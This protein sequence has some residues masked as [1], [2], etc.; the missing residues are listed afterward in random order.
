[1]TINL[2]GAM[3]TARDRAWVPDRM[4]ADLL[5]PLDITHYAMNLMPDGQGYL[6][7]GLYLRTRD[8]AKLAQLFLDRGIWRGKRIV[9]A[10]WTEQATARH[11]SLSAPDDYGFGWWRKTLVVEGT[12]YDAFYASGNGGQLAIAIPA[13]DLMVTFQA[14]NY[15]NFATW[16]RFVEELVPQVI[17]A[18]DRRSTMPR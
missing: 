5:A 1:M 6:G 2:I 11:A 14:G 13:L 9:S 18:V 15:N 10:A 12:S 17:G 4:R 7:G 8:F 16:R 3:I